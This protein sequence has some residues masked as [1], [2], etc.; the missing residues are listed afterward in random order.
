[1]VVLADL[2]DDVAEL[3]ALLLAAHDR[4]DRLER[5]VLAF[6]QAL[7]GRKSEKLDPDQFELAL[8]DIETGISAIEAEKEAH[9]A[10]LVA[11]PKRPRAAN[12]GSLPKHLPRIEVIVEPETTVCGCGA[13]L[14]VIGED[15]S[16]RLDVIPAQFRVIV[17]RRPRYGCRACETGV[18]QAPAPAR[19][20]PGG[21][22]TEATIAHVLVAKYADHLPLYRQAQIFSRQGIDLDRST[23]AHWVGRAAFELK[24]VFDC[25]LADLKRSTKLFMDETRAPVLDPGRRRT[26]T[27]Y[28]WSLARDDQPW[29]GP[30]PPG[31]AYCY[32]PG[33]GGEHAEALL[34]GFAGVLQV[35]GY[36]GYNRLV[37]LDRA[38]GP[39]RLAYC[40]AHA[41]RKLHEIAKGGAA[42][43]AEE[44]LRRIAELY[45]IEAAIRGQTPEERL[46]IRQAEVTPRVDAF[47]DWVEEQRARVS[48][49][50]ALGQALRYIFKLWDGLCLFLE[51]GHVEMDSN[52]VERA[53][54]PIALNRKNAL[55][56]GHDVG[57]ENWGVIASLIETAKLN[58]VE[59]HAYLT[60]SLE[61]IVNGHMQRDIDELLTWNYPA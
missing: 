15:V 46:R 48:A 36:Q 24:P 19:L 22:P 58:N 29:G 60:R 12:R 43:I 34:K 5:L 7:F 56:A 21:M 57:A 37:G 3:K 27:G 14:H 42:P 59:P 9:P 51:D 44:G 53:I 50:S 1:M 32:A 54:R 39:I 11:A 23:L 26:K 33:R 25:L 55:F 8:E 4:N 41:R 6:K 10:G 35:D 31:V 17:T 38:E 52:A 18:A 20:I 49:K 40:W 13:G 47:G 30:D 16:E 61:A 45:R 28:F 2:P